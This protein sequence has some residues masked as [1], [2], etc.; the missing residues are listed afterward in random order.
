MK[1][2][3]KT[4]GVLIALLALVVIALV[5]MSVINAR[6]NRQE[7]KDKEES[8]IH[9]GSLG[10]ADRM[11]LNCGPNGETVDFVLE[12][13]VWYTESMR[14]L[15][16][17]QSTLS[18]IAK[19]VTDLT[20]VRRVE[21]KESLAYYGLEDPLYSFSASDPEG[22]SLSLLVGGSFDTGSGTRYYVM[23]P[24]GSEIYT[25]SSDLIKAFRDNVFDMADADKFTILTEENLDS[26]TIKDGSGKEIYFEKRTESGDGG[27]DQYVWYFRSADGLVPAYEFIFESDN[28]EELNA[29]TYIDAILKTFT[30]S[31]FYK[32]YD[33]DR[34]D[35]E[36]KSMYG[37]DGSL[38][39]DVACT[40]EDE[41]GKSVS[42]KLTFIF[43]KD[44]TEEDGG[45]SYTYAKFPDSKQ[46]NCMTTRRVDPLRDAIEKLSAVA[47]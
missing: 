45:E 5:A 16:M 20:A 17:S 43:G 11:S 22:H 13:E 6:N 44:F 9:L 21:I 2:A 1:N 7:E 29:K 4:L 30:R 25:I 26:F 31:F 46:I 23:E 36:L 19:E 12:D 8:V 41:E 27:T 39:L 15:T 10:E 33:F 34:T 42:E 37:F 32:C 18:N 24:G 47:G 3:K 35:A 40:Y 28:G 38:T 14:G